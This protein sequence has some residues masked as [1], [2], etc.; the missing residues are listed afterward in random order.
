ALLMW[1]CA[2]LWDLVHAESAL[3]ST[4]FPRIFALV[5]VGLGMALL[6]L[7]R[8]ESWLLLPLVG[9]I[10]GLVFQRESWP[11]SGAAMLTTLFMSVVAIAAWL[12]VNWLFT[13][14]AGYFLNS[15][16]SGWRL[17]GTDMFVQQAGVFASWGE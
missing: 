7:L 17:P 14:D 1:L 2:L 10:V 3:P 12:Y 5:L 6:V 13:G 8:Y 16:Y 4:S 15:P 9:V 11:F